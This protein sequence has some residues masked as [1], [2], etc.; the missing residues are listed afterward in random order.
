MFCVAVCCT[1]LVFFSGIVCASNAVCVLRVCVTVEFDGLCTKR[2]SVGNNVNNTTVV[3][4]TLTARAIVQGT[5]YI[6]KHSNLINRVLIVWCLT[7]QL[8]LLLSTDVPHISWL[9]SY[10]V[11]AADVA[12]HDLLR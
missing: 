11:V 2:K 4:I 6:Y 7:M 1:L 3:I 8:H 10:A 9:F 12:L 5:R